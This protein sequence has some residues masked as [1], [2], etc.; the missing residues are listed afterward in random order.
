MRYEQRSAGV[1]GDVR[2]HGAG[3]GGAGVGRDV[4]EFLDVLERPCYWH[5]PSNPQVL[6][7]CKGRVRFWFELVAAQRI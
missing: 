5:G 7:T 3:G 6:V 2:G 4:C 1:V